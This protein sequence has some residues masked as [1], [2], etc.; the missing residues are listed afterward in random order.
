MIVLRYAMESLP[1]PVRRLIIVI[2]FVV[3]YIF[4]FFAPYQ[5]VSFTHSSTRSLTYSLTCR[6]LTRVSAWVFKL[7]YTILPVLLFKPRLVGF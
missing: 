6:T 2:I 5:S 4:Y 1:R 7:G 3:I